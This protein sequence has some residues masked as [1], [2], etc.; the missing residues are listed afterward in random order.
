MSY[1]LPA[2]LIKKAEDEW[3]KKGGKKNEVAIEIIEAFI[4]SVIKSL[5]TTGMP[6]DLVDLIRRVVKEQKVEQK[7]EA[8]AETSDDRY[9]IVCEH[10]YNDGE[11]ILNN[12]RYVLEQFIDEDLTQGQ[13]VDCEAAIH[14][15]RERVMNVR[16]IVREYLVRHGYEGLCKVNCGCG[17]DDLFTCENWSIASECG[18]CVAAKEH[19]VVEGDGYDDYEPGD[20]I[21]V[22]VGDEPKGD[23]AVGVFI[24]H[25]KDKSIDEVMAT[26]YQRSDEPL[27]SRLIQTKNEPAGGKQ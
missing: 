3:K 22:P 24:I 7:V 5:L 16:K 21:Y 8:K 26:K 25:N 27:D 4:S 9:V 18:N 12:S 13:D 23:D 19:I 6:T 11:A 1:G 10:H 14:R 2:R 17:V 15:R 20:V